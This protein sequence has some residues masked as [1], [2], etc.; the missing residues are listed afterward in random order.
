MLCEL[1]TNHSAYPLKFFDREG[2]TDVLRQCGVDIPSPLPP[3]RDPTP[4]ELRSVLHQMTGCRVD[5]RIREDGFDIDVS[6]LKDE[7]DCA[8]I[9]V[10]YA[11]RD[12]KDQPLDSLF[13]HH[14][15]HEMVFRIV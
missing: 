2:G 1:G 7:S 6:D 12:R 5:Y 13:F 10:K 3:S 4:D 14:S 11:D 8:T 15:R 9:W